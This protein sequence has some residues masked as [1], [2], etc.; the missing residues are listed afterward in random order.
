MGLPLDAQVERKGLNVVVRVIAV[1][2]SCK[3]VR[4]SIPFVQFILVLQM[5]QLRGIH[6]YREEASRLWTARSARSSRHG[7][8]MGG[9]G[10]QNG[11]DP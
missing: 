7:H 1:P 10:C 2:C 11:V 9:R 8:R 4:T 5:Q 6:M 3:V